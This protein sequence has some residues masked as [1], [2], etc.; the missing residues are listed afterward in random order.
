MPMI[1]RHVDAP[2]KNGYARKLTVVWT[3]LFV[4]FAF[5]MYGASV[6]NNYMRAEM[7]LDQKS[8][9]LGFT[10]FLL[11]TGL[12]GPA[13][14]WAMNRF[15]VRASLVTG[16]L[17]VLLGSILMA[18]LVANGI[19][20]ACVFGLIIG[21]GVLS[22][23]L[24]GVQTLVARWFQVG[25]ARAMAI[26]LTA[27]G[28]G[29]FVA[30]PLLN[31]VIA[32]AGDWRAGWWLIAALSGVTSLLA[33]LCV[34]ESG[35]L[36]THPPSAAD[37]SKA[38]SQT[39]AL[40]DRMWRVHQVIRTPA[41]WIICFCA[42]TFTVT[43]AFFVSHVVAYLRYRGTDPASAAFAVASMS[44]ASLG[45]KFLVGIIGN[46]FAMRLIWCAGFIS[47]AF[48]IL[49]TGSKLSVGPVPVFSLLC[50]LGIGVSLVALSTLTVEFFGGR[51]FPLLMG[52]IMTV[53][54]IISATTPFVSG[55]LF[56]ATGSYAGVFYAIASMCVVAIAMLLVLKAPR[57]TAPA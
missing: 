24:L 36:I 15:G 49:L 27:V 48:G 12:P 8:L 6:M 50:G 13:M 23:G 1:P 35:T 56:D 17:L 40:L 4:N 5:P 55:L 19:E 9:G 51:S 38:V 11:M 26:L 57:A 52:L 42:A 18:T 37:K 3:I 47:I 21:A 54:T 34:Q 39:P 33:A 20:A 25:R 44:L 41:F 22:G 7:S 2:Q 10:I 32:R 45:A 16:N 29:G 43:L 28:V 31:T 53:Q 46:R 14:A 30:P